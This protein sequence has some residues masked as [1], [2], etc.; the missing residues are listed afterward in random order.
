MATGALS[1]AVRGRAGEEEAEIARALGA[2]HA[3]VRRPAAALVFACGPLAA[4]LE[5]VAAAVARA[6]PGTPALVVSGAGVLSEQGALEGESAAT[7]VVWSGGEASVLTT[8]A[9][10][11]DELGEALARQLGDRVGR[12]APTVLVFLRSNGVDP[13]AL[14]PLR[15]TR[16]TGHLFGAG[17][18]GTP[19]ALAIDARGHI[20]TGGAVS[21][22]LRGAPPPLIRTSAACRLLG[23]L[24][25]ITETRGSMVV[26]LGGE[27]AL[28]VLTAAGESL[29]GQPL[30]L[31]AVA[32]EAAPGEAAGR[33][34]LV[35]RG[36][37]GV[38]PSRRAI[39]VSD[40]LREGMRLGFAVR[41]AAAARADLEATV[42]E[43]KRELAGAV[44]RFGLYLDCAGRGPALYGAPDVDLRVL[45]AG[46]GELPL[47]GMRSAF[48]LAPLSGRPALHLYTG[49]IAL[50]TSPS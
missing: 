21:L 32:D 29:H 5:Q 3:E 7:G 39:V 25:T 2:A 28:D 24:Q 6:T 1:F 30:V 19:G 12:T 31:A 15:I 44:P 43:L 40:E 8:D 22:I 11:P 36:I 41:D 9:A 47:A 42:R 10:T 37:E 16:G 46:L 45:R 48:E 13:S 20:A 49:V 27:P 17:V 38:D 26:R 23:P 33:P 50:F 4:R 18:I 35:L 34:P 14:E